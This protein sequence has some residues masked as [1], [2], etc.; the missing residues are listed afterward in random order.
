MKRVLKMSFKM[1]DDKTLTYT[2]ENPKT[3]LTKNEAFATMDLF[4]NSQVIK[5]NGVLVADTKEAYIYETNT[6]ELE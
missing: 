3:N 6:I 4:V 1:E 2:L 5:R